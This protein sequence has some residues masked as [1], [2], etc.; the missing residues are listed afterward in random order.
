MKE[1]VITLNTLL[2][3]LNNLK[4]EVSKSVKD[5]LTP[6][7][8]KRKAIETMADKKNKGL[9]GFKELLDNIDLQAYNRGRLDIL[10]VL[11]DITKREL[12]QYKKENMC[13]DGS[14][15]N[16]V[17]PADSFEQPY[18]SKCFKGS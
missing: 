12:E 8:M 5:Q 7:E 18:C 15:H 10:A 9:M 2:I 3:V 13:K 4:V 14:E 11:T 6:D 16:Y 17:M 1:P